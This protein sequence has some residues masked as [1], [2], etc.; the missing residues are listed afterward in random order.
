MQRLK[1]MDIDIIEDTGNG[2]DFGG[3]RAEDVVILPA[4]GASVQ[5]MRLLN[6]RGVRIVD[7]TCPWVAKARGHW[8]KAICLQMLAGCSS[9]QTPAPGW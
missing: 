6:D 7:T 5:E 2:K 8:C 1:E 4:F 3:V 9:L